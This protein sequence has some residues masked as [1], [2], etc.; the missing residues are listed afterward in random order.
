MLRPMT[1]DWNEPPEGDYLEDVFEAGERDTEA[2]AGGGQDDAPEGDGGDG[3]DKDDTPAPSYASRDDL[4]SL[5]TRL[6][7]QS[8]LMTQLVSH[9]SKQG[10][11]APA[12]AAPKPSASKLSQYEKLYEQAAE[13]G[14]HSAMA[15]IQVAMAQEAAKAESEG[16]RSDVLRTTQARTAGE[17]MA[18]RI[19]E[20]YQDEF[21]TPGSKIV[22]SVGR[23]KDSLAE[24]L[25]DY[26]TPDQLEKFKS[27][28]AAD[29][30]SFLTAAALNPREVAK[31]AIARE[32]ATRDRRSS[33]IDRQSAMSGVGGGN[34]RSSKPTLTEL[35]FE[36]AE[37]LGIDLKDE[38]VKREILAD[39]AGESLEFY[40]NPAMYG[41]GSGGEEV[42]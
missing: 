10:Q 21:S 22:A 40:G 4:K 34:R 2:S 28:P 23:E 5:E 8:Q 17:R 12:P 27:S 33:E 38:K 15:K 18:A 14:N 24:M 42:A 7:E 9:F 26:M 36:I 16:I 29:R 31:R 37:N 3:D 13:N 11:P 25:S 1:I 30:L 41:G 6:S 19:M 20:N 39:K 35:D 32:K